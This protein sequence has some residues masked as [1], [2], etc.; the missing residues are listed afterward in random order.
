RAGVAVGAG[1]A[2]G[3]LGVGAGA[4]RRVTGASVVALVE[5]GADHRVGPRADAGLAGVALRAGVA[6]GA[7]RA[8]GLL[9]VGAGAVRRVTAACVLPLV[10]RG[11]DR[12]LGPPL[13]ADPAGVPLR[14]GVAVGAGHAVGLARVRAG[15]CGGIAGAGV[16][17]LIERGAG[18]RIRA[19]ADT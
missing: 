12:P 18:D 8:V 14:A 7:G 10:E 1:R 2:V 5:R 11:A 4:V 17:A 16:M 15:A 13:V 9:W 19:R 6:V 3:L